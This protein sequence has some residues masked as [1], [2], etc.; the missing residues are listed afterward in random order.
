M[1]NKL[2]WQS[3]FGYAI[4]WVLTPFAAV[5]GSFIIYAIAVLWCGL[6]DDLFTIHN[7]GT[8]STSIIKIIL[9]FI[10]QGICGYSFV[11]CGTHTAPTHKKN[12]SIVLATI[13]TILCILSIAFNILY[14]L[15]FMNILGSICTIGGAIYYSYSYETDNK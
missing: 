11:F 10:C 6:Q 1:D 13:A 15:S 5:L 4:R 9:H 7:G 8:Q 12:T 2:F 3:K 14:G